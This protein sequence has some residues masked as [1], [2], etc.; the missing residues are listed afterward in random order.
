[1]AISYFHRVEG[2]TLIVVASG[3]DENF[4]E[5]ENYSRGI[6]QLALSNN[7]T[8]VLCD[9]RLLKYSISMI[10]TFDL[11]EITANEGRV[12]KK[13]AIVCQ[14]SDT[15]DGHFFETVSVNRGLNVFVSTDY[16]QAA[17]WL[18]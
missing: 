11:A 6:L 17:D 1:M 15:E 16:E 18:K 3:K 12:L 8:K 7:C 9:E 10:E 5:V 13:I 4:E 2:N 14:V